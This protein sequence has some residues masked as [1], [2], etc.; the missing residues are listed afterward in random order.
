MTALVIVGVLGLYAGLSAFGAWLAWLIYNAIAPA[1]GFPSLGFLVIWGV[2]F[3]L[4]LIFK[5]RVVVH[6]D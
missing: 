5:S 6:R 3:L 4:Q 2:L 1:I